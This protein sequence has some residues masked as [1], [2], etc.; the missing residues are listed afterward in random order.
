MMRSLTS[1]INKHIFPVISNHYF[2]E[3]SL[4]FSTTFIVKKFLGKEFEF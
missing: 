3:V 4:C 1:S 2:L